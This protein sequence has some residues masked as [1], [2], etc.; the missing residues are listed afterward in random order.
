[1]ASPCSML[2]AATAVALCCLF[3]SSLPALLQ[4]VSLFLFTGGALTLLL[5]VPLPVQILLPLVHLLLNPLWKL[6]NADD[7]YDDAAA[8][9]A[10]NDE[11]DENLLYPGDPPL[12]TFGKY[13]GKPVDHVPAAYIKWLIK[14]RVLEAK[15]SYKPVL[16]WLNSK[17]AMPSSS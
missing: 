4:S 2:K 14:E 9:A 17:K 3:L 15:P 6:D 16:D 7:P 11:D 10:A 12:M 5:D 1:M 13:K 8:V